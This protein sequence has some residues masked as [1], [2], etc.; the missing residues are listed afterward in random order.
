MKARSVCRDGHLLNM[1]ALCSAKAEIFL[2]S[3]MSQLPGIS[4]STST[5]LS[6]AGLHYAQGHNEEACGAVPDTSK[7]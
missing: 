5:A 1:F 3:H 4:D 2:S 6:N 7:S